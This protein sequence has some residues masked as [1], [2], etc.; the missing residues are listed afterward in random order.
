MPGCDLNCIQKNTVICSAHKINPSSHKKLHKA[1][2]HGCFVLE[3]RFLK[4]EQTAPALRRN[5]MCYWN[6]LGSSKTYVEVQKKLNTLK[7]PWEQN[8]LVCKWHGQ[9]VYQLIIQVLIHMHLHTPWCES[10]SN[11]VFNH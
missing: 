7:N 10:D 11:I 5:S 9:N 6:S 4:Y 8:P 1:A 2:S 3:K